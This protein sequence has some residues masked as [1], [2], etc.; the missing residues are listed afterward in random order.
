M[1]HEL[2]GK[3]KYREGGGLWLGHAP[4]PLFAALGARNAELPLT[5]EDADRMMADMQSAMEEMRN[6]LRERFGDSMNAAFEQ[7]DREATEQAE[8]PEEPAAEPTERERD[9]DEKRAK[10]DKKRAKRLA[11]GLF[12]IGLAAPEGAIPAPA[13][14]ASFQF[15]KD[16]EQAVLDAVLAQVWESFQEAYEQEHWRRIAGIKPAASIAELS[17]RFAVTRADLSREARGGFAHLVFLIDADWQDEHGLMIVYSPDTRV[18]TWTT[19]DGLDDL[20]ESDD[21][22]DQP[23]EFVPTLHDELLEAILT[24]NDEKARELLAAGA[25]INALGEE[26]YPPLWIAV[27]QMEVE[28]VRRLLEYGANPELINP[29]EGTTPLKHAKRLYRD[30]GF[31]PSKKRTPA[32]DAILATAHEAD[33]ERFAEIRTRLEAIME[34]LKAAR[35]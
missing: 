26:E 3:L 17:G 12:P 29:D 30:M 24:D 11:K 32:M 9:R 1:T 13:Q 16:Y 19:W 35:S 7:W 25:D 22:A 20:I 27:D 33:A 34:L 18:A 14:E 6:L 5:E 15:L 23:E 31:A 21:P 28:E 2:F 10:R 4:L 8:T